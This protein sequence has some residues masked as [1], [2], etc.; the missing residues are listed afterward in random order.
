MCFKMTN[1][2][3]TLLLIFF[4]AISCNDNATEGKVKYK[5]QSLL[6]IKLSDSIEI[7][8]YETGAVIQGDFTE[9][10]VVNFRKEEFLK[11][12]RQVRPER[13]KFIDNNIH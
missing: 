5:L 2:T 1:I 10:F 12:F 8:D 4:I 9:A 7:T 11:I 13:L 6:K 3:Y